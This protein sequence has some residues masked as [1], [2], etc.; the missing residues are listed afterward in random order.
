MENRYLD[1]IE[2]LLVG[3]PFFDGGVLDDEVKS[4]SVQ[5]IERGVVVAHDGR[6]SRG[7]V[8]QGQFSEHV[9][10]LVVLDHRLIFIAGEMA[11]VHRVYVVPVVPFFDYILALLKLDGLKG[12]L[13]GGPFIV[14]QEVEEETLVHVQSDLV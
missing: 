3:L 8:K 4:L 5:S 2:K 6:G 12:L 1:L 10:S 13:N 11:G 9:S 14:V 7:V